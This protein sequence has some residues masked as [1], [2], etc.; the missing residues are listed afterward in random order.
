MA[1]FM[2]E[3]FLIPPV[4]FTHTGR[5]R[6][7]SEEDYRAILTLFPEGVH[8]AHTQMLGYARKYDSLFRVSLNGFQAQYMPCWSFRLR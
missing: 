2:T 5:A 7:D 4:P 8:S 6:E 1:I 3:Q